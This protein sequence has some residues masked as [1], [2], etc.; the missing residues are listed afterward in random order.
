VARTEEGA[1]IKA[2]GRSS[3]G[4][5]V[6]LLGISG[7]N[8]TR[9]VAGEPIHIDAEDMKEMGLPPMH[10]GLMYGRTEQDIANE[11]KTVAG[12]NIKERHK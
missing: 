1:V 5:T 6:L 10:I 12:P 2:V 7:E 4:T 3:D 9:L 11:I 8:V